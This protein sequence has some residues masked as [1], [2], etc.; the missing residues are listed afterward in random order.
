MTKRKDDY[1]PMPDKHD[2]RP[3]FEKNVKALT[4]FK[5]VYPNIVDE[6]DRNPRDSAYYLRETCGLVCSVCGLPVITSDILKQYA[7]SPLVICEDCLAK[8]LKEHKN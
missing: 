7:Y 3:F 4:L 2:D 6:F 5:R 1:P 8:K